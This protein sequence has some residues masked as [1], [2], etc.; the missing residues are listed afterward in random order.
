MTYDTIDNLLNNLGNLANGERL[1]PKSSPNKIL[2][3]RLYRENNKEKIKEGYKKH[4]KENAE[5]RRRSSK[6][7][8]Y[9]KFNFTVEEAEQARKNQDYKCIIC[10]KPEAELKRK[11]LLADHCHKFNKFR[12]FLCIKCNGYRVVVI[13]ENKY[14]IDIFEYLYKNSSISKEDINQI[15]IGLQ[16]ILGAT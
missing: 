7:S 9:K 2:S 5:K 16:N 12:G 1:P 3:M 11:H 14:T 8:Y 15:I 10:G 13:E 4:Y 6:T